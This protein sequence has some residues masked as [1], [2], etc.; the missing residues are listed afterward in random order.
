MRRI[1][2]F[3]SGPGAGLA[4]GGWPVRERPGACYPLIESA[5]TT[6]TSNENAC[7]IDLIGP[8]KLPFGKG[9]RWKSTLTVPATAGLRDLIGREKAVRRRMKARFGAKPRRSGCLLKR[10]YPVYSFSLILLL[11]RIC[12]NGKGKAKSVIILMDLPLWLH[13]CCGGSAAERG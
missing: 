11:W 8:M 9:E 10:F 6:S 7:A 13:L 12:H 2:K 5:V 3:P 4:D 1:C